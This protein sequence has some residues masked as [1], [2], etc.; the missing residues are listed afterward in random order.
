[1]NAVAVLG[2]MV[3]YKDVS[4]RDEVIHSIRQR[5]LTVNFDPMKDLQNKQSVYG[6]IV[7]MLL[8]LKQYELDSFHDLATQI[9]DSRKKIL[10]HALDTSS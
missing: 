7:E 8:I 2:L 9:R 4:H 5:I 10:L 3:K 1:M 6:D